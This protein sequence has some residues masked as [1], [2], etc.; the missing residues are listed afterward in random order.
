MR[1]SCLP[2]AEAIA[3]APYGVQETRPLGVVP[4]RAP[5]GDDVVV[6]RP[7]RG[8]GVEPAHLFDDVE[9]RHDFPPP[10]REHPEHEDVVGRQFGGA[11]PTVRRQGPEVESN[12]AELQPSGAGRASPRAR[13]SS[14]RTRASSSRTEKGLGR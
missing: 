9:T 11:G 14:A 1:V 6:D 4:D 10:R 7:E 5:Q 13:R 12:A 2:Q 8:V 3:L